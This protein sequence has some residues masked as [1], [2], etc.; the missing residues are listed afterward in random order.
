[1]LGVAGAVGEP[2]VGFRSGGFN[3]MT[4]GLFTGWV[5]LVLR[6]TYGAM[7]SMSQVGF[8]WFGSIFFVNFCNFVTFCF[9]FF[10]IFCHFC[11]YVLFCNFI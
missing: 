8:V 1:M 5:G 10:C 6:P 9:V 2:L 3:G 11:M 7:M 4:R